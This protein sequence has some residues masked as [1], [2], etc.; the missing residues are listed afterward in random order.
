[1][2][3]GSAKDVLIHAV[4]D[5]L[6]QK[7]SL[8]PDRLHAFGKKGNGTPS[9]YKRILG[10][11]EP[12]P[13]KWIGGRGRA[14]SEETPRPSSTFPDFWGPMA[15]GVLKSDFRHGRSSTPWRRENTFSAPLTSWHMAAELEGQGRARGFC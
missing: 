13:Y 2:T 15:L 3:T 8:Y 9:P 11:G 4:K 5:V 12:T 10:E 7:G 14:T 1:V 6:T